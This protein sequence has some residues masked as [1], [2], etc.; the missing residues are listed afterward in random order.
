[1][2][3]DGYSSTF[4]G[5]GVESYGFDLRNTSVIDKHGITYG[6]DFRHDRA[7]SIDAQAPWAYDPDGDETAYVVGLYAQDNWRFSDDWLL[8]FG[9][10]YDWYKHTNVDR[11]STE[12]NGF[13]PNVGL[14]YFVNDALSVYANASQVREGLGV[15]DAYFVYFQDTINPELDMSV[16]N[17]FETGFTYDD[18]DLFFGAETLLSRDQRFYRLRNDF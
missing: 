5:S 16:A 14:T 12:L 10:R 4:G 3:R 6:A 1:M 18:G 9:A 11:N 17:N 2:D 7:Y 15:D 13:S 8:T